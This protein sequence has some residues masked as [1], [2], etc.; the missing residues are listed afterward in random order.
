MNIEE[1]FEIDGT[2]EVID[3][4]INV[5]GNVN[6]ITQFEVLPCK[7]GVVTGDFYCTYNNLTNLTGSPKEIGGDFNCSNNK[8]TSLTGAPNKVGGNF[9]CYEN[10]LTSLAGAPSNVGGSF[11]CDEHLHSTPEYKKH[12]ILKKLRA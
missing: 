3:G 6:L 1:Y 12:L 11:V 8:L 9:S 10:N 5:T 2:Y 7:F 4:L